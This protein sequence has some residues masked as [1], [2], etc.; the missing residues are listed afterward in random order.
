MVQRD[1]GQ[2]LLDP[3]V[4]PLLFVVLQL[5][6]ARQG[7]TPKSSS[8]GP[9]WQ[10]DPKLIDLGVPPLRAFFDSV[11]FCIHHYVVSNRKNLGELGVGGGGG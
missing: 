8:L 7:G 9:F 2:K 11:C 6:A 1:S 3:G 5:K 10:N 4:P